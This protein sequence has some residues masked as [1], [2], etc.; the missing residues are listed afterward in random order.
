[1]TPSVIRFPLSKN[2]GGGDTTLTFSGQLVYLQFMWEVSLPHSPVEISSHHHF[3]KLSRSKVA[4]WGPPSCLFWPACLQFHEGLPL[5]P[6]SVQ[7][8]L[9]SLLCVFCCYCSFSLVFFSFF[10]GWGQSVQGGMLIWSRVVCGS[11]T[12]H[13]AHLRVC[14]S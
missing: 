11:T 14:F 6:F 4:G 10:P 9:P 12:C 13:L 1:M 8:T 5:P 3:Y 7:G 2:T